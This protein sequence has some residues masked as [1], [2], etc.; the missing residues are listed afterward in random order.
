VSGRPIDPAS[1]IWFISIPRDFEIWDQVRK[2]LRDESVSIAFIVACTSHHI[3]L[4]YSSTLIDLRAELKWLASK[5]SRGRIPI[6]GTA[7]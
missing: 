4:G 7:G 3:P 1:G 6:A 5:P 2:Y